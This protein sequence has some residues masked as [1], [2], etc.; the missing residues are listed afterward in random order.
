MSKSE[1]ED[2]GKK[3]IMGV[4]D[5]C[6]NLFVEG[7]YDSITTLQKKLLELEELRKENEQLKKKIEILQYEEYYKIKDSE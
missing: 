2:T 6:G 3:L 7:D 4:G 1:L 5:G